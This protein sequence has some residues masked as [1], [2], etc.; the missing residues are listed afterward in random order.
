[1][2]LYARPPVRWYL[3][4]RVFLYSTKWRMRSSL[5]LCVSSFRGPSLDSQLYTDNVVNPGDCDITKEGGPNH[6]KSLS[7]LTLQ[8]PHKVTLCLAL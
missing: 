1:M 8:Y 3:V 2:I 7:N 6:L 5:R 4:C